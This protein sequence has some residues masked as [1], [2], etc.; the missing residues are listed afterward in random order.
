MSQ[1]P[2]QIHVKGKQ[3]KGNE[4]QNQGEQVV[5]PPKGDP[6]KGNNILD[7]LDKIVAT[8]KAEMGGFVSSFSQVISMG[9]NIGVESE[10]IEDDTKLNKSDV[11]IKDKLE[12]E[13]GKAP[14]L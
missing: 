5:L 8:L 14:L 10:K 6:E 12:T 7:K 9:R 1:N 4:K 3:I 2:K 13:A 11:G